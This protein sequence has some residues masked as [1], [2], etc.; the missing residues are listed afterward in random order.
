MAPPRAL[1]F[2]I[3]LVRLTTQMNSYLR[4]IAQAFADRIIPPGGDIPY[5]YADTHGLA[6]LENYLAQLPA[7]S[8]FGLKAMLAAM[9]LGP[10]LFIFRPCRFVNLSAE[11]QDRYLTD[12]QESRIYWRRMALVLLKTLFGMGF[13]SDPQ[14]LKHLGWYETCGKSS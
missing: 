3:A 9:D 8:A 10:I 12:W 1:T 13:Y 6:F 11:N 14:V 7:G 4:R 5:A 2:R